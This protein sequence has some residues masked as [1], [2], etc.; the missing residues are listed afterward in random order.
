VREFDSDHYLFFATRAGTVV[1]VALD[2]FSRPRQTGINAINLRD[3]DELV[4]VKVTDGDMEVILT[5]KFGQ[6]L[7]FH[8][9]AVRPV[10]RNAMG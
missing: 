7:R 1:K 6:S 2:E 3:D 10:R 4:D 5:T 9:E 8:E